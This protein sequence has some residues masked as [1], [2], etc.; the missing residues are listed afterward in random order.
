MSGIPLVFI[1][2]VRP[3]INNIPINSSPPPSLL[4]DKEGK[5]LNQIMLRLR[6]FGTLRGVNATRNAELLQY[7]ESLRKCRERY[8]AECASQPTRAERE[9]AARTARA[10]ERNARWSTYLDGIKTQLSQPSSTLLRDRPLCR[11]IIRVSKSAEYRERAKGN[12]SGMLIE[13]AIKK[14][15]HLAMLH[16]QLD[17]SV[18]TMENLDGKIREAL[19]RPVNYN[20]SPIT[21]IGEARKLEREMARIKV[22]SP[23]Q[24]YSVGEHHLKRK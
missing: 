16:R 1:S 9:S 22:P 20:V 7:Q 11:P 13:G 15:R 21:M 12:L 19:E 6:Y 23:S 3:P 2:G 4:Y 17:G 18:I 14:R 8:R 10:T 5:S 24:L